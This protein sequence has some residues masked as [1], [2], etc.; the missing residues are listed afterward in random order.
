MNLELSI[1]LDTN[2]RSRPI[3]DSTVSPDGIDLVLTPLH[4]SEMF[5]RQLKFGDFDVSEMSFSSLI[6]AIAR[7]DDLI[8]TPVF[9]RRLFSQNHIFVNSDSGIDTP[10]DLEGRRVAE[11]GPAVLSARGQ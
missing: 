6:K 7:G 4:P 5:W 2:P 8:A 9:P 11:D 3:L 10:K 1:A